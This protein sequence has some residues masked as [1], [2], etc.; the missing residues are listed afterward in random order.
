[1]KKMNLIDE[2]INSI[3]LNFNYDNNNYS[4]TEE[5]SSVNGV[6]EIEEL[7]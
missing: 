4:D 7:T 3:I 5:N 2:A 6:S 1:M